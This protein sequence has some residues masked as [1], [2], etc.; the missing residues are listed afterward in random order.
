VGIDGESRRYGNEDKS[1][2]VISR[3]APVLAQVD[4]DIYRVL[5]TAALAQDRSQ[6]CVLPVLTPC[7]PGTFSST[8]VIRYQGFSDFGRPNTLLAC[9]TLNRSRQ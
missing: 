1:D 3:M 8:G 9:D 2:L 6:H 7:L 4:D 5:N